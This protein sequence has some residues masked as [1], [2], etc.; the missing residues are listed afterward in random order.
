MTKSC[1]LSDGKNSMGILIQSYKIVELL[2]A[3]WFFFFLLVT[4]R[5]RQ[6]ESGKIEQATT[7]KIRERRRERGGVMRLISSLSISKSLDKSSLTRFSQLRGDR[8]R[9]ERFDPIGHDWK[10]HASLSS[11]DKISKRGT[12]CRLVV[13]DAQRKG[14]VKWTI[15][16]CTP[17]NEFLGRKIKSNWRHQSAI[18]QPRCYLRPS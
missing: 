10:H 4:H 8:V 6:R 17:I 7:I 12:N 18:G 11:I 1:R 2:D 15:T 14:P 3:T 9:H 5:C 13:T 16:A